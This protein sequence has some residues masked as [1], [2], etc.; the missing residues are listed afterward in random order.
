MSSLGQRI[1]V[2]R[3]AKRMSQTE[4]AEKIG[5]KFSAI[6]KYER[7]AIDNLPAYRIKKLAEVLD[8]TPEYLLDG[9]KPMSNLV[10]D[11]DTDRPELN[12][13]MLLA[14]E[15]DEEQLHKLILMAE[16]IKG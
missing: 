6:S 10:V 9:R 13:L 3:E 5:V 7:G 1:R 14:S 2:L 12:R 8:T 11:N 15:L 16:I 4:L